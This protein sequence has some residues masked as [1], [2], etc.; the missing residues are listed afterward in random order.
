MKPSESIASAS[1]SNLS[2]DSTLRDET[3]TIST[4]LTTASVNSDNSVD[5]DL[6]KLISERHSK[7]ITTCHKDSEH[8]PDHHSKFA[9]WLGLLKKFIGVKD[10]VSMRISLPAQLIEP[11]GN[12][13]Y[14]NYNDRP[15][16]FV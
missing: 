3:S 8:D 4:T 15:D 5:H 14:W 6:D 12:L 9:T 16:Y 1:S 7:I 11:I 2:D 10:I 13:E